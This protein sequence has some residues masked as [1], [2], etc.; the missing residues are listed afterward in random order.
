M[1]VSILLFSILP[2]TSRHLPA[3]TLVPFFTG[4]ARWLRL[5][6]HF[7]PLSPTRA[8][9]AQ[10]LDPTAPASPQIRPC[11]ISPPVL[12]QL[13][14]RP[15]A[16][17][18][19]SVSH[20]SFQQRHGSGPNLSLA[21]HRAAGPRNIRP[22]KRHDKNQQGNRPTT[23]QDAFQPASEIFTL[24][25]APNQWQ[26][27]QRSTCVSEPLSAK[28]LAQAWSSIWG[29]QYA[30]ADGSADTAP[31]ASESCKAPPPPLCRS[32]DEIEWQIGCCTETHQPR[33]R[34]VQ[35]ASH[36]M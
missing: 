1:T 18:I 7:Y 10:R 16:G 27:D 31:C 4:F 32:Y 2:I 34:P 11:Q 25:L 15:R 21:N 35:P 14:P 9:S 6:S 36:K 19:A 8:S 28:Q 17:I 30:T 5:L 12:L 23:A 22:R 3:P 29:H 13:T 33:L 24:P 20:S 26:P